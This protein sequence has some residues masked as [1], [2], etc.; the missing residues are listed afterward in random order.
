MINILAAETYFFLRYKFVFL[1]GFSWTNTAGI[2]SLVKYF[3]DLVII[4]LNGINRMQQ[5]L[6]FLDFYGPFSAINLFVP[7]YETPPG[8]F[9]YTYVS[10][11]ATYNLL[12]VITSHFPPMVDPGGSTELN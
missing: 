4:D 11:S 1:P 6:D 10:V 9:L 2:L 12:L 7:F 5:I 3:S 8:S